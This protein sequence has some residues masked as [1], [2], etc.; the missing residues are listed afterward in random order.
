M[1]V[2]GR[3]LRLWSCSSLLAWNRTSSRSLLGQEEGGSRGDGRGVG[4]RRPPP[5]PAY[6]PEDI[7]IASWDSGSDLFRSFPRCLPRCTL[8]GP[9]PL[10]T[11]PHD[12]SLLP[13]LEYQ[14]HFLQSRIIK[15]HSRRTP[16]FTPTPTPRPTDFTTGLLVT[17]ASPVP[18]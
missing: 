8:S 11:L 4:S 7:R 12:I 18:S 9:T 15:P 1:S 3:R 16:G 6:P 13:I 14:S 17:S 5:R 10:S 2:C